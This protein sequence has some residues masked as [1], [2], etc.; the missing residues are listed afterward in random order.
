MLFYNNLIIKNW[1]ETIIWLLATLERQW[2]PYCPVR[3]L[4]VSR[5]VVTSFFSQ[6]CAGG[7]FGRVHARA[8]GC[9]INE[10]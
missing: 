4:G 10:Y 5:Q 3:S 9:R 6:I 8:A 7:S 1:R 2:Y